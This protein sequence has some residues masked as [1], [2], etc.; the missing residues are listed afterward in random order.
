MTIQSVLQ[1][2]V[3][4]AASLLLAPALS[5]AQPAEAAASTVIVAPTLHP[6]NCGRF[7]VA[8]S[9]DLLATLN[10][11]KGGKVLLC[12]GDYTINDDVTVAAARKVTIGRAVKGVAPHIIIGDNKSIGLQIA[13]SPDV[14]LDGLVFDARANPRPL[15]IVQFVSS[16]GMLRNTTLIG[17]PTTVDAIQVDNQARTAP[18]RFTMKG[19]AARG[20]TGFGLE[21]I[22][23]TLVSVTAAVFDASDGGRVDGSGAT[24]LL[25][26]G[27]LSPVTPTGHISRSTFLHN[28]I[29]VE[30]FETSRVLV[31]GNTVTDS[32]TGIL[33]DSAAGQA[34]VTGNRVIGNT[35]SGIHDGGCGICVVL[36]GGPN[37][38]H[39]LNTSIIRNVVTSGA[40]GSAAVGIGV[41]ANAPAQQSLTVTA[42][43]NR[44]VHF[45][46]GDEII[47]LFGWGTLTLRHNTFVP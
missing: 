30:A 42:T 21:V 40:P 4:L 12:P 15:I 13:D 25:L 43:G 46:P 20:Y 35:V 47:N 9:T 18:A 31:S 3:I 44:L 32:R 33:V 16:G 39:L 6:A 2:F 10:S 22:G 19:G 24:G 14:V 17:S 8:Q 11:V 28:D 7:H 41:R 34:V 1:K 45:V 38:I 5:A 36:S 27:Q 26:D 23:A 37:L 29:G